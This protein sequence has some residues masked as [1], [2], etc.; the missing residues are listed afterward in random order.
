MSANHRIAW[1]ADG[2]PTTAQLVKPFD[3]N[4]LGRRLDA[5][6]FTDAF[7]AAFPNIRQDAASGI[8]LARELEHLS[9]IVSQQPVADLN[10]FKAF[11][12]VPD[13]P[14]AYSEVYTYKG[15]TYS[16]GR[17]S[18][19]YD[20]AGQT[21][22][23]FQVSKDSQFIIPYIGHASYTIQDIGQA[24]LTGMPIPAFK[25]AGERRAIEEAVNGD[26]WFGNAS[27]NVGG[28]Y[29]NANI[30]KAVVA[31][32]AGG[33]PLWSSKTPDEIE[34]DMTAWFN[35]IIAQVN[36]AGM[37]S[38]P[39]VSLM[40][41]RCILSLSA[42][43][44]LATTARSQL[45]NV[46]ILQY[47]EETFKRVSPGFKFEAYNE[48]ASGGGPGGTDAWGMMY[49]FDP[50]VMG[51]IVAM[52]TTFIQPNIEIFRTVIPVHAQ[53]GGICTRYPVAALIRYGM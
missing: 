10:S 2:M 41:D 52:P 13:P 29:D 31:N 32:G 36:Q 39:E 38:T 50:M 24:A 30:V 17:V 34:A 3:H 9:Q 42:L 5:I 51:R 6:G 49:K 23:N 25:L 11:P 15:V 43:T 26:N 35:A 1:S 27:W 33:S 37:L 7:R 48:L 4:I 12:V 18:R 28:V 46:S 40:P 53:A 16:K 19:N 44:K 22:G 20:D 8:A 45:T 14:P 21:S 47:L